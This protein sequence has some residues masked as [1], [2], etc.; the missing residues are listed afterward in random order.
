MPQLKMDITKALL[1]S[2]NRSESIPVAKGFTPDSL[3]QQQKKINI[4]SALIRIIIIIYP[5]AITILRRV[6][7][8]YSLTAPL[9]MMA[10]ENTT[11]D[12][13]SI[14]TRWNLSAKKPI[15]IPANVKTAMK[16]GP[17]KIW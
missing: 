14:L 15:G 12:M 4:L 10:T 8:Q 6:S 5:A 9:S 1:S 17:A 7:C 13:E 11:V 16:L 3:K 2:G